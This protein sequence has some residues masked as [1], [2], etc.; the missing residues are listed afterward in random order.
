MNHGSHGNTPILDGWDRDVETA[1]LNRPSHL[2]NSIS[3]V[4]IRAIRGS[5][6]DLLK[7]DIPIRT[8]P[9]SLAFISVD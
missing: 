3:S 4:Q 8:K 2:N 5:F 6:G 9:E 7:F 1:P